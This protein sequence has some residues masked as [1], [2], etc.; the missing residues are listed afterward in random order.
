MTL[1]LPSPQEVIA[2]PLPSPL[3]VTPTGPTT[4]I[5]NPSLPPRSRARP[6][7]SSGRPPASLTPASAPNRRDGAF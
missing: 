7:S 6:P 3:D 2:P 1:S 4:P 5:P